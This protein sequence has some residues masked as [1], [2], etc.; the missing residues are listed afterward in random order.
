MLKLIENSVPKFSN[1]RDCLKILILEPHTKVLNVSVKV[2]SEVI[3]SIGTPTSI[4]QVYLAAQI[5][6]S[7][8]EL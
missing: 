3:Q 7:D 8:G 5:E 2:L 1:Y 6:L 4:D